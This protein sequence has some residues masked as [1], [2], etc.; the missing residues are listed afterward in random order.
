MNSV[1]ATHQLTLLEQK[2]TES[3]P[4]MVQHRG[5]HIPTAPS[6]SWWISNRRLVEQKMTKVLAGFND[7][8][9]KFPDIAAEA[10]GWDPTTVA[11]MSNQKKDWKCKKGHIYSSVISSRTANGTG[12][13]F[14]SGRKVIVGFNDLQTKYPDIAVEAYMWDPSIIMPGTHQKKDW[15]CKK[16]HIYTSMVNNRTCHGKGCPVCA[17]QQVLAGF[18]DL[19]TKFPD[20]AAEA[21]GWDPATVVA[22]SGQK[23]DWKCKEGHI[24]HSSVAHRTGRGD[25]CPFCSNYQVLAGFNDLKTRFP[26]IAAEAYGWDP[27]ALTSGTAQKKDWQC[28]EGHIYHSSVAHRT[29]GGSGCPVCCGKQILA[30][31]ND[32]KTK[33]PDIAKEAWGWDPSTITAGIATKKNWKCKEGHIYTASVN[34][35]TSHGRGCAICAVSGFNP[36]K[37]AWFYLMERPGEQ[38]I[39]ISNVITDRLRNHRSNGWSLIEH[40]SIPSNGQKVLDT[41]TAFKQWLKKEIGLIEG[42]TE[43]WSTTKME[44]HSLAELKA[45]SGI[46]TDL[47]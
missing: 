28:K 2:S 1:P 13:P 19:K 20:I 6:K 21:Y 5:S 35:R 26:D 41:E 43:N 29:S 7:L 25:G 34:N 22:K 23:K 46:D 45:R 24:Y 10:Y 39:G 38:Q 37:D 11:E 12:C 47:F 33:F 36:E 27:E 17:G 16:G 31:F 42:T 15:K 30:G 8:K 18:N 40:T 9:T 3:T 14:C 4:R 32:L 44:V